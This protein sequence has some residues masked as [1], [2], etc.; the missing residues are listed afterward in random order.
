[1]KRKFKLFTSIAS[2]CLAVALMAFGVYAAT[3]PTLNV[4][5]SVSFSASNVYATVK[6]EKH[7]A[8]A[9]IGD[10][11]TEVLAETTFDE[12]TAAAS[13]GNYNETAA[14]G[15]LAL[16]DANVTAAYRV[17][18]TSD[19]SDSS[20][21]KVVVTPT[22][23]PTLKNED[24]FTNTLKYSVNGG[25]AA[26]FTTAV[27]LTGGQTIVITYTISVDPT[28]ASSTTDAIDAGMLLTLSRA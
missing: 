1:M 14:V 16:T 17:T 5:G 7:E 2:L 8:A 6:V 28:V 24:G 27:E 13:E 4:T 18:I 26:D 20:D 21:A 23:L 19:F 11:W 9:T 3:A 12:S 22:N 25:D 10:T 15:T